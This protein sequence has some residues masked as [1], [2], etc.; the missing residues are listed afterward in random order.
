M[1]FKLKNRKKPLNVDA[2]KSENTVIS[3]EMEQVNTKKNKRK[4][5]KTEVK[6]N[7]IE[8]VPSKKSKKQGIIRP[9]NEDNDAETKQDTEVIPQ[10]GG[11]NSVV[12]KGDLKTKFSSTEVVEESVVQSVKVSKKKKKKQPKT[13]EVHNE[14]NVDE[15]RENDLDK[16]FS[17]TKKSKKKKKQSVKEENNDTGKEQ[18]TEITSE[19]H[20]K[21]PEKKNKKAQPVIEKTTNA[22]EK[23]NGSLAKN[24]KKN[25]IF[26]AQEK[27]EL[28]SRTIFIGNLS[29]NFNGK[30]LQKLFSKFGEIETFRI[31]GAIPECDKISKKVAVNKKMFNKDQ[32]CLVAYVVFKNAQ[33][34]QNALNLNGQIFEERHLRVTLPSEKTFDKNKGIFIGN[35][36]FRITEEEIWDFFKDC[37]EISSVRV[38]RDKETGFCKGFGYVNFKTE[39]SVEFALKLDEEKLQDREI[40]IKRLFSEGKL[41]KLKK[42]KELYAIKNY[43][44][45]FNSR[46]EKTSNDKSGFNKKFKSRNEKTFNDKPGFQKKFKSK[47][48]KTNDDKSGFKPKKKHNNVNKVDLKKKKLAE[49]LMAKSKKKAVS[50]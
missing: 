24:S 27:L 25:K 19:D 42:K 47:T 46:K 41:E 5:P 18:N 37:G 14:E 3:S 1:K 36:R 10:K 33:D 49:K 12:P 31:R 29:T 22:G 44:P 6:D 45:N 39:D 43:K 38:I 34:A 23:Q 4:F 7:D 8:S 48:D 21:D 15:N 2:A 30:N 35:L 40:R 11:K 28:E 32:Q 9:T 16:K 17:R 20:A 50:S 26:K 13:G